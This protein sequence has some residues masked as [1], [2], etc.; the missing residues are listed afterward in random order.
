MKAKKNFAVSAMVGGALVL[1][2]S[3]AM[4]RGQFLD[5][6]LEGMRKSNE[7]SSR[8]SDDYQRDDDRDYRRNDDRDYRRNDDRDYRR[9]R[10][11]DRARPR[12]E[13][14]DDPDAIVRRAYEDILNREPDQEGLRLYRSKIIDENWSEK[15]V[16]S[17]LRNSREYKGQT[18]ASADVIIR[19]AYQDILGREPDQA[20]LATY[21]SKLID[22]GWSERDVRSDLKNS[23]ERRETRGISTEQ[24]QQMVRRAYQS[25]LGRDPDSG[26]SVYVQKILKNHWSEADVAKEL[27]NS[28][29]YRN[30]RN[31]K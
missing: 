28:P 23:S 4:A 2:W 7:S 25:V 26:S 13:R 21:R 19:R 22:E 6:V 17:A 9:Q 20:G 16:R 31:N 29:E 14:S 18:P 24:A 1:L 15:D 5:T 30:R 10:D 3:G 27:K 11:G 8:R 12:Y